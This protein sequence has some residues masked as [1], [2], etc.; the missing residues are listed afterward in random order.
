MPFFS[1]KFGHIWV[2]I[3]VSKSSQ[4]QFGRPKKK[5]TGKTIGEKDTGKNELF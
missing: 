3:V 2:F 4:N 5:V 1:Q